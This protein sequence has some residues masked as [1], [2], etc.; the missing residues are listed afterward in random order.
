MAGSFCTS[1]FVTR[2]VTA[3]ERDGSERDGYGADVFIVRK[4]TE[5]EKIVAIGKVSQNRPALV[6]AASWTVD[7][8]RGIHG[9]TR[10][11]TP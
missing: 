9:V 5:I 11:S 8:M 2:S 3:T 6:G 4:V 10:E 1:R 7:A